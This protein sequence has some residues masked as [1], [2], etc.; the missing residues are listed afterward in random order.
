MTQMRK[1]AKRTQARRLCRFL[2]IPARKHIGTCATRPSNV[3]SKLRNE[4]KLCIPIL[5]ALAKF[6]VE[7]GL[8][9]LANVL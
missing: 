4:A 8:R 5:D 2:Y 7:Q 3:I 6:L 1:F 9:P